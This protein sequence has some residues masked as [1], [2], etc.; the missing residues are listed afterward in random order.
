MA[1]GVQLAAARRAEFKALI[2]AHPR[3]ALRQAVPMVVR[4]QLPAEVVAQLEERVEGRARLHIYQSA[5]LDPAAPVQPP[6]MRYAEFQDGTTYEAYVYGRHTESMRGL[7]NASLHGVAF[8]RVLAVHESPLRRLEVGEIPFSG[9]PAVE[10]CP[11]SGKT[12]LATPPTEA[13]AEETVAVEAHGEII[14]LCDGSHV[15]LFEEQVARLEVQGEGVTGG[16]QRFTGAL[17]ASPSTSLGELRVLYIPL[18]FADQNTIPVSEAKCYEVM[19]DVS[20]FF[21]KAS[22]GRLT[23]HATV[24]PPITL[25]HNEAWYVQKDSTEG[26]SKEFNALGL[27]HTHAREEARK[28]GYDSGDFD[29]VVVR[30]TGGPRSAG[31]GGWGGG[32]SVWMYNDSPGTVAHELGHCFGLAHANFWDT[33]GVSAMGV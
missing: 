7:P 27:E 11:V 26:F 31:V 13:I 32:T 23:A 20:D 17:P 18:T 5:P 10:I 21:Y 9:K 29:A 33:G 2:I 4:Q 22:Y 14:Y 6:V 25:P 1:E 15:S 30:L 12:T 28:L 16:T 24:T 3:E 8:D 19:R